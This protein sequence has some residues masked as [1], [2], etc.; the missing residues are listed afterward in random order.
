VRRRYATSPAR[1]AE[2]Q[3]RSV[4]ARTFQDDTSVVADAL[5]ALIAEKGFA[6]ALTRAGASLVLTA[7]PGG[8]FVV[9]FPSEQGS[10]HFDRLPIEH[11][12]GLAASPQ[13]LAVAPGRE[14][15]VFANTPVI[16]RMHPDQFDA[17][18]SPRLSFYTGACAVH[19][20]AIVADGLLVSNTLFSAVSRVDGRYNFDPVWKPPFITQILPEDCCHLN[21]IAVEG[22]QLRYVTTFGQFDSPR[23]WRT[24][25]L[26]AGLVLDVEADGRALCQGLCLPHS[27]R[28]IEGRLLVAEPR[29]PD[30]SRLALRSSANDRDSARIHPRPRGCRWGR[31]RS[32]RC[33]KWLGRRERR[34]GRCLR[35]ARQPLRHSNARLLPNWQHP[36]ADTSVSLNSREMTPKFQLPSAF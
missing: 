27:P 17:V 36:D 33:K 20:M 15:T 21:G 8:G 4:T 6:R 13:R 28:L 24:G 14:I 5:S 31:R 18:F 26:D 3:N 25:T 30:R 10:L 29:P 9:G 32:A 16:A 23:G 2:R 11:A 22:A 19:D 34:Y 1:L 12:W 35:L 7:V